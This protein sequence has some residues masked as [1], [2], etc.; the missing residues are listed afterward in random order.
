M[1][2][3]DIFFAAR[4]LLHIPVWSVYLIC[5]HYNHRSSGGHLDVVDFLILI[6]LNLLF[7]GAFYINQ[8]FDYE[9][10]RINKKCGF[11][12][13]GLVS[14]RAMVAAFLIMSLIPVAV[15][16]LVSPLTLVIFLQILV[17][18][19]IY[20]APPIRLKDRPL[21]GLLTNSYAHGFLVAVSVMAETTISDVHLLDW[22]MPL[23]FAL[24]VGATYIL[25]T[26]PDRQGDQA[27]GKRTLAVVLGQ[28]GAMVLALVLMMMS[29]VVAY[30]TGFALLAYL[31]ASASFLILASMLIRTT[32]AVLMAAKLPLLVLTMLAGYYYPGYLLF[33]VALLIGTRIYYRLRFN[34]IYPRLT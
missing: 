28:T 31:S 15:A 7:A 19:Y 22:D 2:A 10:D 20:S 17:L 18:A 29:F 16:P 33:I 30:R 21:G 9:S 8:V 27:T 5:L 24:T 4:P 13:S 25:T 32:A 11:L 34:I 14:G 1:K 6:C 3:L 12:Q 26:I 23:Y